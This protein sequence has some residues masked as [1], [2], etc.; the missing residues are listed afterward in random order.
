MKEKFFRDKYD[1]IEVPQEDVKK[2]IRSGMQK[3]SERSGLRIK[4]A[5]PK[6]FII[7]AA[8]SLTLMATSFLVPSVSHVMAEVP[9]VGQLYTNFNDAV[10]RNLEEQELI[11]E[12]DQSSSYKGIDVTI[13]SAY[14]DGAMVGVTFDISGDVNTDQNGKISAFYQIFDGKEGIS[15]SKEI[16]H[17]EPTD[18][19]YTGH[20]Q[21]SYPKTDLP[22]AAT[23]PLEFLRIGEEEGA[24]KF[25]VPIKQ[26]PFDMI[27]LDKVRSDAKAEVNVQFD[28]IIAGKASTAINYTATFPTVGKHDQV[29]LVAYDDEGKVIR[30][31]KDGIDL[32][33]IVKDNQINVKGRSIIPQKLVGKTDYIVVHPKVHLNVKDQFVE[34]D[35]KTP[36]DITTSRQDLSVTVENMKVK[37]NEFV[38]DFQFNHGDEHNRHFT[39]FNNFAN[40][41]VTLVKESEKKIRQKP[42]NHD[43]KVVD[44]EDLRFRSSFDISKLDE[45]IKEDYVV[46]VSLGSL[47]ANIPVELEPVKI[48]LN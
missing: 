21:L 13:T 45:F 41:G 24:W 10:G 20:V 36:L 26:L 12:L 3:A 19:G 22:D 47:S 38:I 28:S 42:I 32:E 46:R 44:K 8:A 4:T 40:N 18:T 37:D 31:T 17:L 6:N 29:E 15:D 43:I 1:E 33:T 27:T 35:Q 23:F 34:L 2:A 14:Y 7:S 39:H 25:D 9:L 48:S 16:V 30:I 11:T 5:R